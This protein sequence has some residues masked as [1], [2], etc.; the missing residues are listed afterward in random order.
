MK[1]I[2]I[3]PLS[4]MTA[5]VMPLFPS[6]KPLF[7]SEEWFLAW[8]SCI[9]KLGSED[10]NLKCQQGPMLGPGVRTLKLF[11]YEASMNGIEYA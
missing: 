11:G 1:Q 7:F 10:F 9:C 2:G 4:S 5:K 6:G 3:V 8:L